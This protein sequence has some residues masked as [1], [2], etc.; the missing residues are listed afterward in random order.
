M[1][2]CSIRVVD[3]MS[4]NVWFIVDEISYSTLLYSTLLYSSDKPWLPPP[5]DPKW[6]QQSPAKVVVHLPSSSV[7][8][9]EG[10][11]LLPSSSSPRF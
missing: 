2:F 5:S 4:Q 9:T 1:G 10:I 8:K 7:P 3:G 6:I 11:V